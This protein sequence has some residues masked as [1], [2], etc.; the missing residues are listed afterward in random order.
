MAFAKTEIL[1]LLNIFDQQC[2]EKEKRAYLRP[3]TR[4]RQPLIKLQSSISTGS[5]YAIN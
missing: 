3:G 4:L 1:D 2:E 5:G